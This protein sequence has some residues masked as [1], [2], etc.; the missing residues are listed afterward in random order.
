MTAPNDHIRFSQKTRLL[1][2]VAVTIIAVIGVYTWLVVDLQRRSLDRF[3][4]LIRDQASTSLKDEW[5]RK[6]RAMAR[7]V[8]DLLVRPVYTLDISETNNIVKSI[9]RQEVVLYIYAVDRDGRVL[10]DGD[11][12]SRRLGQTL[13]DYSRGIQA[14]EH[15]WKRRGDK[16]VLEINAPIL[17]GKQF[18]GTVVIGYPTH[19]IETDTRKLDRQLAAL[20]QDSLREILAKML[21]CGAVILLAGIL[22]AWLVARSMTR[23]L[24]KLAEETR[25]IGRGEFE[26]Q[27]KVN[28]QDELG[29]LNRSLLQM[30]REIR[31]REESLTQAK[32]DLEKE[33]EAAVAANRAKSEFLANM[34]HELRTPLN[35]IIGFTELVADR[36]FGPLNET[37]ADY[38]HDVLQSSQHLLELINDIL[39]LSKVEAGKM[40]VDPSKFQLVDVLQGS[41]TMVR[42]KSIKR[43]I[44]LALDTQRAPVTV[45]ADK[46]KFK[47]IL[48]NLLSNAVK[49]T[50]DGGQVSLTAAGAP[51]NNGDGP[52]VEISVR[53]TGIGIAADDLQRIFNTFEQVESSAARQFDGT[54]LGLALSRRLVELHGGRIWAES[55]GPDQGSRF[56]FTLPV[57]TGQGPHCMTGS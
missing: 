55:G 17:L 56:I 3:D 1:L 39:D 9:Q 47:Q 45:R 4:R 26:V 35:H 15:A 13:E 51:G 30:S 32:H 53:D 37:Q 22:A 40:A 16:E 50:P 57:D 20:F 8:A 23:P 7:T 19:E 14:I 33:K 28:S 6:M 46:R 5:H 29:A 48:Y 21:A 44:R 31:Q 2:M 38:L 12:E 11:R 49:F 34:S 43:G 24:L 10:G 27:L 41:L 52:R 25:K 18:L 54:G 36:H 42:E